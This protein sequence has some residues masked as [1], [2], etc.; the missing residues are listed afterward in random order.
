MEKNNLHACL[1]LKFQKLS[2]I[3]NCRYF[4]GCTPWK[5]NWYFF[6]CILGEKKNKKQFCSI[7]LRACLIFLR[8]QQ[9]VLKMA[10]LYY[11]HR[12]KKMLFWIDGSN[13]L[14][15]FLQDRKINSN[16]HLKKLFTSHKKQIRV[17][18]EAYFLFLLFS[19]FP[20][21][22]PSFLFHSSLPPFFPSD[23]HVYLKRK[24]RLGSSFMHM[25][26]EDAR[27]CVCLP[28]SQTG[29]MKSE[30]CTRGFSLLPE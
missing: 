15:Y 19:L 4:S 2:T 28:K 12:F 9:R 1:F 18:T 23:T 5:E 21:F 24:K 11:C 13:I 3:L 14:F 26:G 10:V 29:P 16:C 22:L 8:C 27:V 17:C 7:F 6:V 30:C 20:F 25:T